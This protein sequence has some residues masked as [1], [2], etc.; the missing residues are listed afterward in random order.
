MAQEIK[1]GDIVQ[2]AS[3][4]PPMN[5]RTVGDHFALCSWYDLTGKRQVELFRLHSLSIVEKMPD[6][7]GPDEG[8][9]TTRGPASGCGGEP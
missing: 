5:V 3:G 7:P 9:H 8:P 1:P 2:L 4:G 6:P